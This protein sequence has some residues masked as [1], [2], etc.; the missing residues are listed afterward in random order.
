MTPRLRL[1]LTI[2][3]GIV[4]VAAAGSATPVSAGAEPRDASVRAVAMKESLV[5]G[6]VTSGG[7]PLGGVTVWMMTT[8]DPDTDPGLVGDSTGADGRYSFSLPPGSYRTSFLKKHHFHDFIGG[9]DY[10][11]ATVLTLGDGESRDL[12]DFPMVGEGTLALSIVDKQG[13]GVGPITVTV[14]SRAPDGTF[15]VV[16]S[17]DTF[18]GDGFARISEL[19]PG[20][21]WLSFEDPSGARDTFFHRGATLA[22]STPVTIVSHQQTEIRDYLAP[23]PRVIARLLPKVTGPARV[24]GTLRVSRGEWTPNANTRTVRW[25]ADGKVIRG[26]RSAAY[27]LT[28]KERGNRISVRVTARAKGFRAGTVTTRPTAKVKG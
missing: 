23:T 7:L 16:G 2:V 10:A 15:T 17:R 28:A 12:G 11:S 4:L 19:R 13:E 22:T 20:P 5:T 6:R 18:S 26:A 25:L 21:V 1:A 3:G 14:H 8:E 24:G 9:L 27:T